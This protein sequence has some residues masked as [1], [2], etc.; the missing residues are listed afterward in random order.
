MNKITFVEPRIWHLG[1]RKRQRAVFLPLLGT[2]TTSVSSGRS[3]L[4]AITKH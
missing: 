1:G 2:T 3:W 4:K